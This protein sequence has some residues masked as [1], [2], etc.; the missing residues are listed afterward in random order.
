MMMKAQLVSFAILFK[1]DQ[2]RIDI[3][4]RIF[5]FSWDYIGECVDDHKRKIVCSNNI[6]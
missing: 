6:L 4:Y 1:P 5:I 2:D 3:L